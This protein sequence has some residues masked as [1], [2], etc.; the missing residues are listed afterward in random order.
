MP[1]SIKLHDRDWMPYRILRGDIITG[2]EIF[3]KE[4]SD[5][6]MFAISELKISAYNLVT[7]IF[8]GYMPIAV[9][10]TKDNHHIYRV[11]RPE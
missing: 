1:E 10:K 3:S 6:D 11:R 7:A 5:D 9:Y 2:D 8:F 4:L